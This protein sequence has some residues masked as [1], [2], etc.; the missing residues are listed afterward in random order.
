MGEWWFLL[1]AFLFLAE[2]FVPFLRWPLGLP[3]AVEISIHGFTGLIL[4][5]AFAIMLKEDRIPKGILV[6][7]GI[8]FIWGIVAFYEGQSIPAFIWGWYRMFKYPLIGLFAYLVID[9]PRDFAKWFLRF[10]LAF[11]AFQVSVQVIMYALGFPTGDAMGGTFGWKGSAPFLM[12]VFFITSIMLGQWLATRSVKYLALVLVLGFLGSILSI[13]KFYL[14]GLI[15]MLGVAALIQ[16]IWSGKLRQFLVFH[17]LFIVI[18]AVFLPIYNNFLVQQ[19]MSTIQEFLQDDKLEA[20]LFTVNE[21]V[22]GNYYLGRG[23]SIVYG[24]QQIQRDS[25]TTMF[26]HGLGSRSNSSFLG[27]GG[28]RYQDDVYGG[29]SSSGLGTWIQEYGLIGLM[30]FLLIVV[31]INMRLFK[32]TRRITD[33]YQLSLTY[34]LILFTS[35]LPVWLFYIDLTVA[36]AMAIL[37]CVSLGYIFRLGARPATSTIHSIPGRLQR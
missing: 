2:S 33:P 18:G 37:Y 36:S 14:I 23:Q 1:L 13:T 7:L 32:I 27:I 3:K 29:V 5:A 21:N 10:C 16:I 19:G 22:G 30:V 4:L 25:V 24:W 9:D 20:Y 26:G 11:L 17:L 28:I 15:L 35:C 8:T 34:G 31:L 6:V 12:L